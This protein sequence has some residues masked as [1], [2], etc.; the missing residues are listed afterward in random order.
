MDSFDDTDRKL[1]GI[2]QREGRISNAE[3]AAR[4]HLSPAPCLRRV[5]RLERAGVIRGYRAQLDA[6][7]VGAGLKAF[8]RVK[9]GNH[10]PATVSAFK[11]SVRGWPEVV[12]CHALT[13]DADFMLVVVASGLEDYSRFMMK[14]LQHAPGIADLN[15]AIA[16]ETIKEDGPLPV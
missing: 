5:Q 16:L 6:A 3:L 15:T 7:R 1:L 4:V 9:L 11:Q 12:A 13:G 10:A 14:R 2:L 8:V